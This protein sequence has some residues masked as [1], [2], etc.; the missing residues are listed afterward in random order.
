MTTPE[1]ILADWFS[2][3]LSLEQ[4]QDGRT[5]ALFELK[6]D[7]GRVTSEKSLQHPQ[8]RR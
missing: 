8:E 4:Y 6:I 1:P 5:V 2:G 3:T 7:Q